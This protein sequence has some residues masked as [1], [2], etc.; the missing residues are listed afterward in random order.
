MRIVID[1][2]DTFGDIVR[3]AAAGRAIAAEALAE[4]TGIASARLKAFMADQQQPSEDEARKL[5]P[6]LGL[7]ADKLADIALGRWKPASRDID[8]R[9]D[10]QINE[11]YPSNG[12]FI[13]DV[14][15]RVAA[16]VD[17]GGSPEN[18]ISKL[19]KN[20]VALRY[21]LLTHKHPDHVDALPDVRQAFPEAQVVIHREDAAAVGA[22]AKGAMSVDDGATLPFGG[23]GIKMIHTP[24]H[25]DGS[26]CFLY[27][28]SVFTGDT[29]FAGS[30]GKL[31]GERFGYPDL[32]HS[33]SKKIF[34]LPDDTLVFP[35]HGPPSTIGEEKTH[36][37]FF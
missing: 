7:D 36:N 8:K 29:L 11:P 21:I 16:F 25:T 20:P 24:G 10:H 33:V 13:L 3:K 32:M 5:A 2:E 23:G 19:R 17:P 15:E 4:G 14:E 34:A 26:T 30:V 27:A 37:P 35:G 1:L 18:I 6:A 9:F 31:F 22:G 12:Y 28:G